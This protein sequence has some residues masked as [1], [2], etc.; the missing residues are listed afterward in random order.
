MREGSRWVVGSERRWVGDWCWRW[1]A[2]EW[3][4]WACEEGLSMLVMDGLLGSGGG[5]S[6]LL[7]YDADR[8]I[9]AMTFWVVA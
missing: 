1:F 9:M 3:V 2:L 5:T 7:R 6:G 4:L 8:L